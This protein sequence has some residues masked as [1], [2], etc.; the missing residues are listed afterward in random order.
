MRGNPSITVEHSP[1]WRL[2][3]R[4]V[5]EAMRGR[6]NELATAH[7]LA[8]LCRVF[9][10]AAETNPACAPGLLSAIGLTQLY[11]LGIAPGHEDHPFKDVDKGMSVAKIMTGEAK[12][13]LDT[14]V[15]PDVRPRGPNGTKTPVGR[16]VSPTLTKLRNQLDFETHSEAPLCHHEGYVGHCPMC[17]ADL[18]AKRV[19]GIANGRMEGRI[20]LV[21][22][23]P[24]KSKVQI[25]REV[26]LPIHGVFSA[27][28]V[29]SMCPPGISYQ[30]V[31]NGLVSLRK[32]AKIRGTGVLGKYINTAEITEVA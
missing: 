26:V 28:T 15:P 32:D 13:R 23:V 5:L 9:Q 18:P 29:H 20:P 11:G 21:Q 25:V 3:D 31:Q 6:G 19:E 24:R 2:T 16:F 8:S 4:Q 12:P 10:K 22:N 17:H 14:Y 7:T 30:D 1:L 27:N